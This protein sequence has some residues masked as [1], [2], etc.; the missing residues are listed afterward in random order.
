MIMN[1][2]QA[3]FAIVSLSSL[4][5][6]K[7][8]AWFPNGIGLP[9]PTLTLDTTTQNNT[10][11]FT[12]I[13]PI[14]VSAGGTITYQSSTSP[15][16]TSPTTTTHTLTASNVSSVVSMGASALGSNATYYYRAK[17]NAS[18]WSNTVTLGLSVPAEPGSPTFVSKGGAGQAWSG[19]TP[20]GTFFHNLDIGYPAADR[21]LIVCPTYYTVGGDI[22]PSATVIGGGA[23]YDLHNS[24]GLVAMTMAVSTVTPAFAFGCSIWYANVPNG[25]LADVV[26]CAGF[27]SSAMLYGVAYGA[28]TAPI[29]TMSVALS[30]P[31]DDFICPSTGSL[32]IPTNGFSVAIAV[33]QTAETLC[34]WGGGYAQ[35]QSNQT[36]FNITAPFT[37]LLA[38]SITP[39]A[40]V[41]SLRRGSSTY[42]AMCL[43]AW[44]A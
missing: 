5:S 36:T 18:P 31:A 29:D 41:A 40:S 8:S 32:T 6:H 20:A 34:T 39:G 27:K 9:A 2:R 35:E 33:T 19:N 21:V 13:V 42:T 15:S 16:F 30:N 14:D 43:A 24:S 3:A 38:Q 12:L 25:N 17:Y 26:I 23:C 37:S 1:R 10:P 28:A 4:T 7:A 44:G 11:Q 22:G